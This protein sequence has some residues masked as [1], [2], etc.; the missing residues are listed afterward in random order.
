MMPM[1]ATTIRSSRR[2]KPLVFRTFLYDYFEIPH[3]W[4]LTGLRQFSVG[5]E[6]RKQLRCST[7]L[8]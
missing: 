8:V 4:F 2:V 3:T 7:K 5:P 6:L 1:I